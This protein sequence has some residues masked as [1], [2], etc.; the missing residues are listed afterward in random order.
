[1][2]TSTREKHSLAKEK[3]VRRLEERAGQGVALDARGSVSLGQGKAVE[4]SVDEKES[5]KDNSS[6]DS[7]EDL[8]T[9]MKDLLRSK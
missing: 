2:L 7:D 1:M 3:P 8:D 9:A 6:L 4:M 5:S